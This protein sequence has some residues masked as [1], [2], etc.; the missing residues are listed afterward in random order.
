ARSAGELREGGAG[1]SVGARGEPRAARLQAPRF[2]QSGLRGPGCCRP[3][4][5]ETEEMTVTV[6]VVL[7]GGGTAGHT[8]P[9]LA[10]A[11]A[12]REAEPDVAIACIGTPRGLEVDLIPKSGYDLELVRPVP[13]PRKPGLDLLAVPG[14]LG[15]AVRDAL[16]VFDRVRPDVVAGFGGYAAV[17]A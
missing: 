11:A 6:R 3:D 15:G 16:R 9:L 12:L 1:R 4:W 13:L 17:P 10:T 2:R 8:S 14:R 7:A 5:V